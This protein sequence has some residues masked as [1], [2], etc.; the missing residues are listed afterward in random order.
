MRIAGSTSHIISTILAASVMFFSGC[1]LEAQN[2]LKSTPITNTDNNFLNADAPIPE[3]PAEL[4][5]VIAYFASQPYNLIQTQARR[6]VSDWKMENFN[7]K[8]VA[9]FLV[10]G[11]QQVKDMDENTYYRF[12]FILETYE[13]EQ[14]AKIR[15][16]RLYEEPPRSPNLEPD[17]AF[18]LRKGFSSGNKVYIIA[19]DVNA[20]T[21][22][23][24]RLTKDLQKSIESEKEL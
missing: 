12:S 13:N 2:S 5:A 4:K 16:K 15:I 3:E 7:T 14:D 11:R 23:L 8:A 24:D 20:F 18:P 6:S 9:V 10:K 22:E 19:T 17:K 21:P 1:M